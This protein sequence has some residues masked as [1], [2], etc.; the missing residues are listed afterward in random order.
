[1]K[2]LKLRVVLIPLL[3]VL[4]FGCNTANNKNNASNQTTNQTEAV[5]ENDKKVTQEDTTA[6]NDQNKMVGNAEGGEPTSITSRFIDFELDVEY[7]NNLSYDVDF[8]NNENV[9]RAEIDDELN[10]VYLTGD[11]AKYNILAILER[12]T[13]DENTEDSEIVVQ[14]LTAFDL[15][16][17]FTEMELEVRFDTGTV[18]KYKFKS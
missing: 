6:M 15:T 14:I 7:A 12:L 1:M 5:S 10:N 9:I 2:I 11:E 3:F 8:E 13:F 16:D 4:L 18:K 17:D